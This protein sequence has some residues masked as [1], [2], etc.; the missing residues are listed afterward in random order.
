ELHVLGAHAFGHAE[1]VLH[2]I[3]VEPVQHH[4]EDHGISILLDERGHPRLQLEGPGAAEEV[5]HPARAVLEGE[6]DVIQ[7]GL[8][9]RL[10]AR[11]RESDAGGDEVGIEAEAVRGTDDGLEVLAHERL[12]A[13]EPELHRSQ[14]PRLFQDAQPLAGLELAA[15]AAEVGRVVA[16]DA[17]Q[18]TAIGELQKEPQRRTRAAAV[19]PWLSAST[20]LLP[21]QGN[22]LAHG[23]SSSQVRSIAR[24]MNAQTS[25][26]SPATAYVRSRS[27][28]ISA[29]VRAP[30]QRVRI[31]AALLLSCTIP[32]G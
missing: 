29:I 3:D 31:A 24:V 4:V 16:E 17:M 21:D 32:S 13:R 19:L 27:V 10:Q 23:R 26:I 28:T 30:S 12:A 15:D 9:Q 1:D 14:R 11:L 8:L 22:R 7:P 5:V 6:L 18:R 2:V 20:V 25:D